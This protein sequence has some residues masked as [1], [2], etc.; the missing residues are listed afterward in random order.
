MWTWGGDQSG[1][2][3][4][5]ILSRFSLT[6]CFKFCSPGAKGAS[7]RNTRGV[8]RRL[9]YVFVSAEVQCVSAAVTPL[10]FSDH[11]GVSAGLRA[12]APVFGPG[13]WKLNVSVLEEKG[14]KVLFR[15]YFEMCTPPLAP[16]TSVL[17]WWEGTKTKIKKLVLFYCRRRKT[18]QRLTV[19]RLQRELERLYCAANDGEPLDVER[20][21]RAKEGLAEY[22]RREAKAFLFRSRC[23]AL[24]QD[25][26]CSSFFFGVVRGAQRKRVI[27]GLRNREGVV[28]KDPRGMVGVASTF[29]RDLFAVKAVDSVGAQEMLDFVVARVPEEAMEGLERDIGLEELGAA[30]H[31][32][33]KGKVPGVDGLP[34]ELY[35]TF[36]DILG[37]VLVEVSREVAETGRLSGT[38]GVGV[39][40]LLYKKGEVTDLGN[41]C[42]LTMLC[43][44]Y[45][46]M[47][48]VITER[49]KGVMAALVSSDQTC[50]VPGRSA[51]WNLQ[52]VRDAIAWAEDRA[53]ALM[54]VALDQQK[55]F[56]RVQHEF[57]FCVLRHMGFG[58]K[59]LSWVEMFYTGVG[60]RVNVNGFLGEVVPQASGVRQG[61]PLS[62]LLYALYME[63][64]AAAVR[65]DPLVDGLLIPGSGGRTV[66]ASQYADDT[67]LFLTS[68]RALRRVLE[69]MAWFG[70]FSGA[71]LN[72]EKSAVMYVGAWRDRRD[73]VGGLMVSEVPLRVLGVDFLPEGAARHN[74]ASRIAKLG[75]RLGCWKE[76]RLSLSGKVL[77]LKADAL[78]SLLYL[79]RVFPLPL[80]MRRE[81]V[82]LVFGFVWGGRYPYVSR[83][84]M[85][86][87]VSE[88]GRDVPHFPLKLDCL[89]FSNLCVALS[90]DVVHTHA[91]IL[92]LYG[93][94][95]V[96]GQW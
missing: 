73:V 38:M 56:D 55:A 60:S 1:T 63:P 37:P 33:G 19:S 44:D 34:M 62:P 23:V 96:G 85:Y 91:N 64:F 5:Q 83:L 17:D 79:D 74:W 27:Y 3:L 15:R 46:L 30:M 14:F 20:V 66:K 11:D 76:R 92:F 6:D 75:Q 54:L 90:A 40:S 35:L 95:G 78:P 53:V 88:G 77:V 32:M 2:L 16:T 47:A 9:D 68:D 7:W 18:R 45:K 13:Y 65:A 84:D 70:T 10:W 25:E 71:S 42:P 69:L 72:V 36:W 12:G 39:L 49:L 28:V 57:L 51:L 4:G 26:T 67:T 22:Y 31:S 89:F 59:F 21:K 82:R 93:F 48:K 52:L 61:C 80:R 50:G 58:G 24:G 86:R 29:Y 41:W 8:T 87:P 94:L 43:V 81:L